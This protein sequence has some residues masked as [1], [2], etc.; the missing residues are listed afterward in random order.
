MKI[1][2]I[3]SFC[4]VLVTAH[5][6]HNYGP[7]SDHHFHESQ[8]PPPAQQPSKED[9]GKMLKEVVTLIDKNADSLINV[10]E[11]KVWLDKMHEDM[12]NE[13]LNQ[14]W[15]YYNPEV[16]EVHSWDK[17][18]PEQKETISWEHY[19][20]L[21]YTDDVIKAA[22]DSEFNVES[23]DPDFKSY[24]IMFK[25][26]EK[27]WKAADANNDNVLVKDEFKNFI[28]PEESESTKHIY[29]DEAMEDMDTDKNGEISLAEYVHH[30]SE[31]SSDEE[32]QD[33][34]F[35]AVSF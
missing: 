2:A 8:I 19:V 24:L 25:R 26:A 15:V 31:V 3:I 16:Q 17:Y 18:N 13:N 35:N 28:H 4:F 34:N 10:D 30:M 22:T 9:I 29:V 5:D 14:Q 23:D 27:R 11:L 33:P 32:K 20:N 7:E 1:L 6:D 12:V 21:T